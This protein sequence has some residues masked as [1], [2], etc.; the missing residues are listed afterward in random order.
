MAFAH[1][2]LHVREPAEVRHARLLAPFLHQRRHPFRIGRLEADAP[3]PARIEKPL[4]ARRQ[5][6]ALQHVGVV[7][8]DEEVDAIGNPLPVLRDGR[9]RNVGKVGRF[10]LA[11]ELLAREHLHLGAV[12]LDHVD[13]EASC[14]RLGQRPLHDFLGERAPHLD[15]DAALL[16][17]CLG[18][19]PGL[20]RRE[21]G[22][23]HHGL[24]LRHA[25]AGHAKKKC[26]ERSHR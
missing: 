26:G 11:E 20:R 3:F 22:V 25:G 17:E 16:L 23:E 12:G 6:V 5:I 14:L 7:S 1:V 13:C 8:D 2:G 19:R 21:R 18:E 4:I 15:L 24:V 9:R 10:Q